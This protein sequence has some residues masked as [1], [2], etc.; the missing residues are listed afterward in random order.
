[1]TSQL[2]SSLGLRKNEKNEGLVRI[3]TKSGPRSMLARNSDMNG[4][5]LFGHFWGSAYQ[6]SKLVFGGPLHV[7]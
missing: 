5:K 7:L 3:R 1:V 2:N 4:A 6:A